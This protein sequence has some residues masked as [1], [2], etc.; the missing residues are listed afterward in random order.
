MSAGTATL[1]GLYYDGRQPRGSPATLI[2]AGRLAA[3]IGTQVAQR[4]ATQQLR[5]S[6][7]VGR[8]DRFIALSDGGQ[9]H[10]ADDA[11]LD[12]LPQESPAEGVVAWLEARAAVALAGVAVIVTLLLA[13]YFYGLPA[14]A[15]RVVAHIPI[16]TERALGEE[17]LTWLDKNA[18]F[19]PSQI[20]DEMQFFIRKDFDELRRGLPMA[21]HYRLEFRDSF[22]GPNALALP[23]GAIVITDAMVNEAGSLEEI[24]AVLAHEIGHVER[25]HTL[26]HLLQDS[27]VAVVVATITADAASLSVAV[28]GL[29]VLL[30][31]AKYSRA[32]ETEADDFAFE[33][34]N[35]HGRS[36]EAFA[37]LMERLA[38]DN[39][40]AERSYAFLSTHPMTN[41]RAQR[42]RAAAR[43]SP[44]TRDENLDAAARTDEGRGEP[45]DQAHDDGPEQRRP[46]TGDGEVIEGPRDQPE[47]GR[48]NHQQEQPER[49]DGRGQRQDNK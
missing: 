20:G 10:C 30:A 35:R 18:W 26:R 7:R 34:L 39:G 3:L 48:V 5:V 9:F 41:E 46:E 21:P 8:A 16:E 4:Y 15:E 42:A 13:G 47:H 19:K 31:Q 44:R 38:R 14:A 22:I 24:V 27:A 25:R 1:K 2:V 12:R 40:G 28:A 11:A 23:G 32:F 37:T 43:Q 6:P 29:P 49:K 45:A 36:P 17:A 33:L